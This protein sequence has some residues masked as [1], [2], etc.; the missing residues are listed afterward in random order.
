MQ[1]GSSGQ[2]DVAGL[3]DNAA[4][5]AQAI[6]RLRDRYAPNVVL[7]YHFSTW[8]TGTDIL[9]ADPTDETGRRGGGCVRRGSSSRWAPASTL[10]SRTCQTAMR[11]SSSS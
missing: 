5:F 3:A 9:Y 4:G 8:A 6:V 11:V 1:V 2:A 7:G 10:R